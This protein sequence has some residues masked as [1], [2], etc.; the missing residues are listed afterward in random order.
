MFSPK[1]LTK[2][3]VLEATKTADFVFFLEVI[4]SKEGLSAE[5][6]AVKSREMN[7]TI[8]KIEQDLHRRGIK[9]VFS[10]EWGDWE[11][12]IQ[13]TFKREN[14]DEIIYPKKS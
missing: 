11:E 3:F 7:E 5:E 8:E 12:K 10:K 14:I 4:D 13:S 1:Q 6:I 9:V 2:E